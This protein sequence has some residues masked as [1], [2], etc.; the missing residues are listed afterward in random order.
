[1]R[2]EKIYAEHNCLKR[3]QELTTKLT[4]TT[5]EN[6]LTQLFQ[7]FDR[8]DMKRVSYMTEAEKY[9]RHPKPS[10]IYEWSPTV[11]HTSRTVTYWKLIKNL[12]QEDSQPPPPG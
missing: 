5:H 12:R 4:K 3:A 10:G 7:Q 11:E 2:L 1:M 9:S 8:M 6:E